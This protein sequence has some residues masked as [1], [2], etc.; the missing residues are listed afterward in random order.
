MMI[1]PNAFILEDL[2]NILNSDIDWLRFKNKSILITGANGF[3]PA[4]MVKSLI[5]ANEKL[6]DNTAHI[7]ALVRNREKGEIM[8]SSLLKRPDFTIFIQDVCDNL[9][10]NKFRFDYIIHAAS[11]AS[12]KYYQIDPVGT[13]SANTVGTMNMLQIAKN[14]NLEAFLYFS[15]SEVYGQ[16]LQPGPINENSFGIVDPT[17]LR[18]CYTESK[19]AGETMCVAFAHQYKVPAKIVRPFHTYGPGLNL[20]DGRVFADFV[21]NI[22]KKEDIIMKSDGR[23]IRSFCYLTDATKGFFKIL[24]E[25]Q[26]GH[27]YNLA[28][29]N[30]LSSVVDLAETLI[31][32]YP[33]Y[34]LKL[35]KKELDKNYIPSPF[36][37]LVPDIQ[38]SMD[39]GWKPIVSLEEGFKRTIDSFKMLEV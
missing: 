13:L 15:S 5:L 11:Q 7:Y 1:E 4:Y 31:K 19:R 26:S 9:D 33:Q 22:V 2:E 10:V 16:Q 38:K 8:F 3:L 28:N 20:E 34:N 12:P 14:Q 35:I 17:S 37:T 18:S 39:L 25:G 21:A 6:L 30:A 36:D 23:A 24:L 29:P 27:A 32:L